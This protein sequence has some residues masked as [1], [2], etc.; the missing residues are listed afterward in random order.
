V[1]EQH[2]AT[3]FVETAARRAAKTTA[4]MM[5]A[6]DSRQFAIVFM[7]KKFLHR[8]IGAHTRVHVHFCGEGGMHSDRRF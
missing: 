2:Q 6:Q 5:F 1:S 4:C 8:C 7:A 3:D